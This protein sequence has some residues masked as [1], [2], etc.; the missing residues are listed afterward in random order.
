MMRRSLVILA[1]VAGALALLALF[2]VLR[3]RAATPGKQFQV[4]KTGRIRR[5]V[6]RRDTATVV[7]RRRG[8]TWTVNGRW[9]VRPRAIK[10]LLKILREIEVKSPVSD[11]L[12]ARVLNDTLVRPVSV[13]VRGRLLPIR[14]FV[15]VRDTLL[16]GNNMMRLKGKKKWFIT[17]FPGEDVDPAELFVTDPWY[18]RDATLFRYLPGEVWD[19]RVHYPGRQEGYH[20]TLDTV[21]GCIRF[22]PEDTAWMQEPVDT[23]KVRRYLTYFQHLECDEYVRHLAADPAD[24]LLRT[25]PLYEL[26]L[27]ARGGEHFAMKVYPLRSDDPVKKRIV[28]DV[29]VARAWVDPPGEWVLIRYFRIDPLFLKAPE[30]VVREPAV[31]SR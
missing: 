30:F 3:Q 4:Q 21:S 8:D 19:V 6:L 16:P 2:V 10:V 7:L 29:D 5:I 18:W 9:Q 20:V 13:T 31:P 15:V 12:A 22:V 23:E 26:S 28:T 27:H 14:T 24:T 25:P 1:V 17:W 11:E